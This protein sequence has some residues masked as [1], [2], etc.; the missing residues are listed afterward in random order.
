MRGAGVVSLCGVRIHDHAMGNA[1][2]GP[3]HGRSLPA[4]EEHLPVAL[5]SAAD[6]VATGSVLPH[7]FLEGHA[8][9]IKT[10][11]SG[12]DP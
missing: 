8:G 4:E 1:V 10:T 2:K 7:G 3:S 5:K 6:S 9:K 12:V 11:D